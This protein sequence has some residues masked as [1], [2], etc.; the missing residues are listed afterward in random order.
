MSPIRL[1]IRQGPGAGQAIE[2]QQPVL[3][4]GRSRENDL[5]VDDPQISRHHARLIQQGT[6]Y[7]LEDLG[8]TNGTFVNNQRL[9][10]PAT[11]QPGDMIRLGNNVLMDV[12]APPPAVQ[13]MTP[14]LSAAPPLPS[15]RHSYAPPPPA[16][17]AWEPER[18]G[19]PLRNLA[20]GCG[21]LLVL[22]VCMLAVAFLLYWFAPPEL[23]GPICDIVRPLPLIGAVC[24]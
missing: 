8:S 11:I 22:M 24:P 14:P 15:S 23:A 6:A 13:P 3:T 9:S 1:V 17:A 5:H 21:L 16:P 10:A 19:H 18:P 12:Q 4:I 20:I 2:A 7:V